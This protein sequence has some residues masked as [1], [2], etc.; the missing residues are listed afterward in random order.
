[1]SENESTPG[2]PRQARGAGMRLIMFELGSPLL[3]FPRHD[4]PKQ[5]ELCWH[6]T[7]RYLSAARPAKT[8]PKTIPARATRPRGAV[9]PNRRALIAHIPFP[10]QRRCAIVHISFIR[11]GC[12]QG[13]SWIRPSPRA[14]KALDTSPML[15]ERGENCQTVLNFQTILDASPHLRDHQSH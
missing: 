1:M 10:T 5:D 13:A 9:R 12:Q 7:K 15:N 14:P 2:T 11:C 6:P 8:A 3:S 4:P